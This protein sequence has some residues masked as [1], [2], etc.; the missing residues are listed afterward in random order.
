[1]TEQVFSKLKWKYYQTW[2][3]FGEYVRYYEGFNFDFV[4]ENL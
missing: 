1:M 4:E 3:T 2:G